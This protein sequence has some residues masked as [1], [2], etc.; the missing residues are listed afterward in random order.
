[1]SD[2]ILDRSENIPHIAAPRTAALPL[3]KTK[4]VLASYYNANFRKVLERIGML[5]VLGSEC[6]N[7][8]TTYGT[9]NSTHFRPGL[10]AGSTEI[11]DVLIVSE[12]GTDPRTWRVVILNPDEIEIT[13]TELVDGPALV[14][15]YDAIKDTVIILCV[16]KL[17][18]QKHITKNEICRGQ[19]PDALTAE[20]LILR[21]NVDDPDATNLADKVD[22]FD[23]EHRIDA[24]FEGEHKAGFVK[25][26]HLDKN[27]VLSTQGSL[28]LMRNGFFTLRDAVSATFWELI[29]GGTM[30]PTTNACGLFPSWYCKF[31]QT[32]SGQGLRQ[33]LKYCEKNIPLRM[34]FYA[35]G[36]DGDENIIASLN[37]P[38][39]E[40]NL[41]IALTTTPTLYNLPFIPASQCSVYA[42]FLSEGAGTNEWY[43]AMVSVSFGDI[44]TYPE[45]SPR[46]ALYDGVQHNN[47]FIADL[48]AGGD[49]TVGVWTPAR[50]I[51]ILR[52]D[53]YAITAPNDDVV[54]RLTDGGTDLDTTILSGQNAGY[55]DTET[56]FAMGAPLTL[57]IISNS[58]T[59][60]ANAHV[61]IQYTADNAS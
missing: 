48:T 26:N 57:K 56:C 28:N 31:E 51:R 53:A 4:A 17:G 3:D 49:V 25:N 59:S 58:D 34:S 7:Y 44:N 32:A 6:T 45:R 19:F 41:S 35:W 18:M 2:I 12:D 42:R 29:S 60:G 52:V 40:A 11:G 10:P 30:T 16:G 50:R 21:G 8:N 20:D 61:I 1:M 43:I 22:Y 55:A 13:D 14:N 27:E 9:S 33:L 46:D 38:Y 5:M 37:D 23:L 24:G 36:K 47:F 54:F 15:N 39:S